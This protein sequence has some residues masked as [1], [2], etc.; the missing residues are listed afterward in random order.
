MQLGRTYLDAGKR[1]EAQQTFNRLV[2][3]F[4]DSPFSGDARRELDNLKK[5]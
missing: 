5:T 4:P 3:E 2:E 1:S